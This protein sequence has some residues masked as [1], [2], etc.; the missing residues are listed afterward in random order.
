MK[1]DGPRLWQRLQ[2]LAQVG[3][4]PAGGIVRPGFGSA[5]AEAL[6]LIA[7]WTREAGLVPG[8]DA[9]GNLIAVL[10]G[11]DP[12]LP[13]I[14]LGS[15]LDTVPNGGAFD[16]ALGVLAALEAIQ[17]LA[18]SGKILQRSVA[19]IGFADE[20]GNNFGIGVLSAQLWTGA[21][22][23]DRFASILDSTGRSL[24]EHISA[25]DVPGLPRVERPTLAAFIEAHIEQGPVLEAQNQQAA[26]VQAI[27][28]VSRVTVRLT[29]EANHAGTTPMDLRRDALWGAAELVL[30]V[31]ELGKEHAGQAVATVG[32]LEVQPGA[33][34]VI[35]GEAELRVE[36]RAPD[37]E[38]L[39]EL[40]QRV[41]SAARAASTEHGLDL[42]ISEWHHAPP[43]PMHPM[44]LQAL[45]E[46]FE[47]AALPPV[48]MPSWAGHDAK[49]LARQVPTGMIFVP[50]QG[51]LS[52]SPLESSSPSDCTTAAQLLLHTA[53]RLDQALT[54][55]MENS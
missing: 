44:V 15:H 27:V 28:G 2:S 48:T 30:A 3:A 13:A 5:H 45:R 21:I 19:V 49:I 41:E 20:E 14:G 53:Q 51:G 42:E 32:V 11:R 31:R 34:N 47:D 50:S 4:S 38:L 16:G 52:H 25:F 1:V 37:S 12:T 24:L 40:S 18:E 29:G 39:L 17:T 6:E 54:L 23:P 8:L 46:S 7:G 22:T 9:T 36:L 10:P 26:A 35:P 55:Q 43:V 33:T